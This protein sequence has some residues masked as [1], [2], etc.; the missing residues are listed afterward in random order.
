[1]EV[2][3]TASEN[4]VKIG[5]PQPIK[6]SDIGSNFKEPVKNPTSCIFKILFIIIKLFL[7]IQNHKFQKK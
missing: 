5:N 7:Q 4:S 2:V 1:M 3:E 6:D